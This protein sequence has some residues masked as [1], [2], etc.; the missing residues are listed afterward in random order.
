MKKKT[1][2]PSQIQEQVS[3]FDR[4]REVLQGAKGCL[5]EAMFAVGFAALSQMLEEDRTRC[6]GARYR[7]IE[8]RRACRSGYTQGQIELAGRKISMRRPRVRSLKGEEIALPTYEAAQAGDLLGQSTLE[9]ILA[10]ASSR[11]YPR[12]LDP[13][14]ALASRGI[15]RSAVSRRFIAKTSQAVKEFLHRSLEAEDYPVLFF[16]GKLVSR[17][18]VIVALGIDAQGKKKILGLVEGSTENAALC[19][20]L[21]RDLIERGLD[22]QRARLVV[23]DGGKGLKKAIEEVLGGRALIQRC[24]AHKMRNVLELLPQS[25]RPYVRERFRKAYRM[26]DPK[27]ASRDLHGLASRIEASDPQAAASIR[28]GLEE[29]LTVM[30]LALP[31]SLTRSLVTSN[32]IE[33]ALSVVEP[34]VRRVKRWRAGSMIVRWVGAGL[35]EA[36]KRFRSVRGYKAMPLLLSA[37]ERKLGNSPL[38]SK[39]KV[40]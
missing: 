40:A 5:Q 7:H 19:R 3:G 24:Q 25:R 31:E 39:E 10:G 36:E 34:L 4:F 23:L 6:V 35:M 12:T 17:R 37:L 38:C 32:V 22:A 26:A 18:A 15:S 14:G 28:E 29:T 30:G 33:S 11:S 13:L 2:I 1:R 9:R 16:D 21:L 20:E 8:G 27:V